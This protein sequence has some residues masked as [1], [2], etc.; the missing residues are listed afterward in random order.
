M[1]CSAVY[2]SSPTDAYIP[3]GIILP[4]GYLQELAMASNDFNEFMNSGNSD[5]LMYISL[6]SFL[7]G[8]AQKGIGSPDPVGIRVGAFNV[9]ALFRMDTVTGAFGEYLATVNVQPGNRL[10]SNLA[11]RLLL[12]AWDLL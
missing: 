7:E 4:C 2:H 3:T 5:E 6:D 11:N 1:N 8:L 12:D 9:I 10:V